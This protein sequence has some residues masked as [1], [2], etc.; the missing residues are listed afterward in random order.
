MA[1]A[2]RSTNRFQYRCN[3]RRGVLTIASDPNPRSF[4]EAQMTEDF[5]KAIHP[6][7][8]GVWPAIRS[9]DFIRAFQADKVSRLQAEPSHLIGRTPPARE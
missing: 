4:P 2:I 9:S 5:L 3:Q 8:S 7:N 6:T 1:T